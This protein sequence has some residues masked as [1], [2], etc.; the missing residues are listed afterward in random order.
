MMGQTPQVRSYLL[1]SLYYP[2]PMSS[3]NPNSAKDT[4]TT[5]LHSD[6]SLSLIPLALIT[7]Y[8]KKGWKD[9]SPKAFICRWGQRSPKRPRNVIS[10]LVRITAGFSNSPSN[11]FDNPQC[12]GNTP[13]PQSSLAYF[14]VP[15]PPACKLPYQKLLCPPAA[16]MTPQVFIHALWVLGHISHLSR[17]NRSKS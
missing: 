17:Q 16:S 9:H 1:S 12:S 7:Q 6:F 15:S 8:F 2:F 3:P 10:G 4:N 14:P 11:A 13:G 5:L